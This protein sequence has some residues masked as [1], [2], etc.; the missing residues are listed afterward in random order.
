MSLLQILV[1]LAVVA[2]VGAVAA[3]VVRGGLSD[4]EPSLPE[5]DLPPGA[6]AVGDVDAVRF[7]LGFRGY[8]M[9]EVDDVLDRL[10]AELADREA[11]LADCG[12]RLARHEAE[13]AERDAEITRLRSG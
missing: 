11:R 12:S 9:D 10:A 6:L 4:A 2:G 5:L 3:G 8:R 1:V 7:S 13:L